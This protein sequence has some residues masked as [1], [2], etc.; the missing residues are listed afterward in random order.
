MRTHLVTWIFVVIAIGLGGCV[1]ETSGGLPQPADD[2]VRTQAQLDLARGYIES[3]NLEDARRPLN[4]ALE[5]NP[6]SSEAHTLLGVVYESERE[7]EL[8]EQ[9]YRQAL[10]ANPDDPQA[11]NNYGSFLYARGRYRESVDTLRRL[12]RN[13]DYRARSQAYENLGLAELRIGD[14]NAAEESFG[15]AVQLNS[16][17]T[18][19][20][21]EL[22]QIAFDSG[23]YD[24]AVA[25]YDGFRSQAEQTPRTLC[26][27]MKLAHATG[28]NDL[29]ASYAMALKNLYPDSSEARECEV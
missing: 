11:L 27:G 1:T 14:V 2:D 21:L 29:V 9:H 15:R 26:L 13:P 23:D 12:V 16:S 19:S 5:I 20:S 25:Y 8:A 22:A 4:K 3:G 24:A 28:N 17:Q 10:R 6:S 18:R 7:F